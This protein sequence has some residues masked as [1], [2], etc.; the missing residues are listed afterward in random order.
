MTGFC[1]MVRMTGVLLALLSA[2]PAQATSPPPYP[3][4][5][6]GCWEGEGRSAGVTEAWTNARIGRMLGLGQT[7]R[8][9]RGGFEF[10]QIATTADASLVFIAQPGGRPP[11]AFK[12]S[13]V[14]PTRI[15]FTNP[16]HDAPKT[17]EY[18]R[19]GERLF[20]FLDAPAVGATP[21]FS[22]RRSDCATIFP[23]Q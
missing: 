2:L 20:A 10:M 11:V 15:V 13:V 7:L 17:I 21:T 3:L 1:Q 16:E 9:T 6:A 23:G 18:R 22:F 19:D 8:G 14:E 5:L 12:A 4:W